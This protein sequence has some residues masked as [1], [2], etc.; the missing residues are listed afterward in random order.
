MIEIYEQVFQLTL[1]TGKKTLNNPT[2]KLS[3]ERLTSASYSPL[4]FFGSNAFSFIRQSI[5]C[6]SDIVVQ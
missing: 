1:D 3:T 5:K 6:K 4:Y 2:K